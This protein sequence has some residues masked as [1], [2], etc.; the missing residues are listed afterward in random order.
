MAV[1]CDYRLSERVLTYADDFP[2]KYRERSMFTEAKS[3]TAA[4]SG[5]MYGS[6]PEISISARY[7]KPMIERAFLF[8]NPSDRGGLVPMTTEELVGLAAELRPSETIT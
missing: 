8:F 5:C 6:F 2:E 7:F 3:I 1:C 4:C